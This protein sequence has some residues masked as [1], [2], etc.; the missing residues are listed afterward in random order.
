MFR[1]DSDRFKNLS[2]TERSLSTAERAVLFRSRPTVR[3]SSLMCSICLGQLIYKAF[4]EVNIVTAH[5]G[6]ASGTSG[7]STFGGKDSDATLLYI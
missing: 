4:H 1:L 2:V 7:I 5:A 6:T 3:I